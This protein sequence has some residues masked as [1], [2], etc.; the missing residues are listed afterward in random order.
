[1]EVPKTLYDKE[2]N[3]SL[4]SMVCTLLV[5]CPTIQACQKHRFLVV[6][7]TRRTI[8]T[9]AQQLSVFLITVRLTF[10]GQRHTLLL[11]IMFLLNVNILVVELLHSVY[12]L[13]IAHSIQSN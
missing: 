7:M 3:S 11:Y 2:S 6:W 8:P 4:P 10:P 9:F 13:T 12:I 1:M 5:R